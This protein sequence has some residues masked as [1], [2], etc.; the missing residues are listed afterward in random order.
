MTEELKHCP[1][2][3]GN[4]SYSNA[5]FGFIVKCRK[6][7]S[8]TSIQESGKEAAEAWNTRQIEN[9]LVE[10]IEKLEAENV[11]LQRKLNESIDDNYKNAWKIQQ[12]A[13]RGAKFAQK[14]NKRLRE[15][16]EVILDSAQKYELC[17]LAIKTVAYTA[18]KG[19]ENV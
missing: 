3:G 16:L 18:L 9:E 15:A 6:C 13:E 2:C 10:K 1:F 5:G 7:G 4:G 17:I 11:R 19:D 14:E 8:K 12:Q